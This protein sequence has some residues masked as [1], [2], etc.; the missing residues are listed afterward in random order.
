MPDGDSLWGP[1]GRPPWAP[2]GLTPE[3]VLAQMA[4][5]GPPISLTGLEAAPSTLVAQVPGRTAAANQLQARAS[6]NPLMPEVAGVPSLDLLASRLANPVNALTP[7]EVAA[8]PATPATAVAGNLTPGSGLT[9]IVALMALVNAGT[10]KI[11]PV[12]YDPFKRMESAQ[13]PTGTADLPKFASLAGRV[14]MPTAVTGLPPVRY[15]TKASTKSALINP[16]LN[17]G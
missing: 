10:H 14:A 5:K 8:S 3:Q 17:L 2:A 1:G 11:V 13:N 15:V 4:A 9:S 12:D 7:T 16:E 6:S